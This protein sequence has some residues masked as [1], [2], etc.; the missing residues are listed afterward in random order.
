MKILPLG[1]FGLWLLAHGSLLLAA[2]PGNINPVK[3][4]S[5]NEL[6][7]DDHLVESIQGLT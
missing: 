6:F 4:G 2:E 1:L 7:V 5:R 3:I